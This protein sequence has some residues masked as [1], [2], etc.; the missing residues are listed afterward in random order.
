M[1]QFDG[2]F[3]SWAMSES[4]NLKAFGGHSA[5][6]ASKTHLEHVYIAH[7]QACGGSRCLG[8]VSLARAW[9]FYLVKWISLSVGSVVSQSWLGSFM[10]ICFSSVVA[11]CLL[12]YSSHSETSSWWVAAWIACIARKRSG[13]GLLQVCSDSRDLLKHIIQFL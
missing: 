12:Y 11:T 9:H 6:G 5:Y 3:A 8:Q 10:Y 13:L 7:R 2:K 4:V 1:G